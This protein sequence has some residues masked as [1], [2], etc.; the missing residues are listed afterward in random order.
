MKPGLSEL[1]S[2][3]P[4]SLDDLA[5]AAGPD[6][7]PPAAAPAAPM[8]G[9]EDCIPLAALNMPD[10]QEQMQAPGQG[11]KVQYTIEG[12]VSRI[13]GDNAY[14]TR[15]SINGQPAPKAFGD[16]PEQPGEPSDEDQMG[17]LTEQAKGT[18][19]Q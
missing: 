19:L 12:T 2:S 16:E 1:P 3:K 11:D 18:Q 8:G 13:E 7:G 15:E 17:E 4:D 10:D 5:Q 9:N 14:V 6:G